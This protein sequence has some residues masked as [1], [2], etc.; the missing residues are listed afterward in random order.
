MRAKQ[1]SR[2]EQEGSVACML[3][4]LLHAT[5]Q[6]RM[7]SLESGD[8]QT[9]FPLAGKSFKAKSARIHSRVMVALTLT[10]PRAIMVCTFEFTFNSAFKLSFQR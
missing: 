4:C 5:G 7:A 10:L 6:S 1:H 9:T 8:E 2:P 3:A